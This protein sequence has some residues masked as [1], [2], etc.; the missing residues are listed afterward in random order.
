MLR[1]ASGRAVFYDGAA[2]GLKPDPEV[3]VNDWVAENIILPPTFSVSGKW[4]HETAPHLEEIL[5]CLSPS[6]PCEDITI[7]KGQQSAVTSALL[8]YLGFL[9]D[10]Y[11]VNVGFYLPTEGVCQELIKDKL[12]PIIDASPVFARALKGKSSRDDSGSS[13]F[14]KLFRKGGSVTFWGANAAGGFGTHSYQVVIKDDVTDWPY[15][16]DNRGDP[17]TLVEGRTLGYANKWRKKVNCGTPGE[18]GSCRLSRSFEESDQRYRYI[19]CPHCD[20]EQKLIFS[21]LRGNESYP[22]EA[23]YACVGCGVLIE[24]HH[25]HAMLRAARWIAEAP[26]PG[27]Q[28]GF[29]I[30]QLYSMTVSWDEIWKTWLEAKG[31]PLLEKVFYQQWLGQAYEEK[32]DAPDAERLVHCRV[33]YPWR[34]IPPDATVLTG[35]ADVQANRIEFGV[36]AWKRDGTSWLIDKGVLEGDTN[37]RHVWRRLLEITLRRYPDAYGRD[38]PIDKFAVDSGFLSPTV[39]RFVSRHPIQEMVMAIKGRAGLTQPSIGVPSR[40]DVDGAGKRGGKVSLWPVGTWPI[41]SDLYG[42]LRMTL[43]GPQEDGVY[44][45]GTAFF[46]LQCDQDYFTQLTSEQYRL[47]ERKGNKTPLPVWEKV[48]GVRNE[49]HDIAVYARALFRWIENGFDEHDWSARTTERSRP[50]EFNQRTLASLWASAPQVENSEEPAPLDT[51]PTQVAPPS[52]HE[53]MRQNWI[54]QNNNWLRR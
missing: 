2:A 30:N 15:D 27:R 29:A 38:W 36:F 33:D 17:Y 42:S 21:Q 18:K 48:K 31:K 50:A 11:P 26:G 39:Y 44:R 46:N 24:H 10:V 9:A 51:R 4:R 52:S 14:K 1:T 3:F 12:Q 5:E 22:F 7:I 40:V 20:H 16:V 28:P 34:H 41:K 25:K 54:P 19:R 49:A 32:S 6:H 45:A 47:V 37:E 23:R 8:V 53:P 35:A 43:A 13:T